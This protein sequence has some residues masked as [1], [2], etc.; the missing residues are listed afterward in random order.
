LGS[1]LLEAS[2]EVQRD[3]EGGFDDECNRNVDNCAGETFYEWVVHRRFLV[4]QD[5]GAL[6]ER[7]LISAMAE[8]V[9]KNSALFDAN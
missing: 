4:A 2:Q 5:D 7:S 1:R 9:L 6:R 8:I 3:G